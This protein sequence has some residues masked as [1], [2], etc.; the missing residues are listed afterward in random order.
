MATTEELA[1]RIIEASGAIRKGH[2]LTKKRRCTDTYIDSKR[3][4][5]V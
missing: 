3:M 4:S 2:F 5:F 1:L